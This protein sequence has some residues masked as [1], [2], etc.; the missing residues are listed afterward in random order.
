VHLHR[1]DIRRLCGQSLHHPARRIR[2]DAALVRPLRACAARHA[3][4][5]STRHS[6]SALHH[7]LALH[8]RHA[9]LCFPRFFFW[10]SV[11]CRQTCCGPV[12]RHA[13]ARTATGDQRA[14]RRARGIW[15]TRIWIMWWL[16]KILFHVADCEVCFDGRLTKIYNSINRKSTIIAPGLHAV[17]AAAGGAPPRT[18]VYQPTEHNINTMIT[19]TI[20]EPKAHAP[21]FAAVGNPNRPKSH[22]NLWTHYRTYCTVNKRLPAEK[23]LQDVV[24]DAGIFWDGKDAKRF[25]LMKELRYMKLL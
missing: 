3:G 7:M 4:E 14:R 17:V 19:K 15:R 5:P 23:D 16:L 25:L 24:E 11:T 21:G 1:K 8:P 10:V 13:R 2:T 6:Y 12:I 20:G 22:P 18:I 9:R